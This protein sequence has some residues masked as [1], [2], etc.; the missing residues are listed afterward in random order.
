MYQVFIQIPK[1]QSL[2]RDPKLFLCGFPSLP[3]TKYS[4]RSQGMP[5]D[6]KLSL[7]G[8]SLQIPQ[9]SYRSQNIPMAFPAY[10]V[11]QKCSYRSQ[12]IPIGPSEPPSYQVIRLLLCKPPSYEVL[13]QSQ[14]ISVDPGLFLHGFPQSPS[15]PSDP[16]VFLQ[17]P[18]NS[19]RASPAT[20]LRSVPIDPKVFI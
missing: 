3:V 5:I 1:S 12:A 8:F 9:Y 18:S 20:Q 19:Y 13:L 15:I 11:F 16:Q 4:A 17:F 10:Q 14:S 7:Y 2:P 6:P